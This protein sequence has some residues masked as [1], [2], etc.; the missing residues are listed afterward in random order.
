MLLSL[1]A[2]GGA[3]VLV[4]V[5]VVVVVVVGNGMDVSKG[6]IFAI[7]GLLDSNGVGTCPEFSGSSTFIGTAPAWVRVESVSTGVDTAGSNKSG[8]AAVGSCGS[9]AVGG[10]SGRTVTGGI[11]GKLA[12]ARSIV[13]IRARLAYTQYV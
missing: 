4:V 7:A 9:A 10:P 13:S 2:V 1:V 8:A 6:E 5:V 12:Y 11:G 3:V